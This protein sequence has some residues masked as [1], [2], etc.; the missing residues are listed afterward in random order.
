MQWGTGDKN[1]ERV[2]TGGCRGSNNTSVQSIVKQLVDKVA[3]GVMDNEKD[4]LNY[5]Y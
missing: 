1:E 2:K 3:E 4:E 5:C